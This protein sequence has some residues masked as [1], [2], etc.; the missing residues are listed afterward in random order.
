MSGV[1]EGDGVVATERLV[2][3]VVVNQSFCRIYNDGGR[4]GLGTSKGDDGWGC[5]GG[6][7]V[8]SNL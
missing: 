4:W 5:G 1:G 7:G 3:W 8:D 6:P 2:R